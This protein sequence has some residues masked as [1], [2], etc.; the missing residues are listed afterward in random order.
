MRQWTGLCDMT[1]GFV[2]AAG[3]VRGRTLLPDGGHGHVGV[4][5]FARSS[6]ARWPRLIA[7]G[8]TPELIAPF[9]P[10]RF[11]LRPDGARRRIGRH[12]LRRNEP[13]GTDDERYPVRRDR[14]RRRPQR[15]HRRGLPR[16]RRPADARAGAPGDPRRRLRD[17]GD[18]ARR[19]RVDDLLHRVHA[20]P[21]GDPRSRARPARA[22]RWCRASPV[23]SRSSRTGR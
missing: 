8:R 22:R 2:T 17:G 20:P 10:D 3:R 21:R 16:A 1:P 18:R 4:Q 9:G 13:G 7:T 23:C 11:A 15:A 19:A 12:P 5:G 6:A 14:G